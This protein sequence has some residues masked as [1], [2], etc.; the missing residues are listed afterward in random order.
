M[1]YTVIGICETAGALV[2]GPL[3]AMSFRAGLD[4]GGDWLGLP[5]I[6]AGSLFAV[7]AIALCSIGQSTLQ[8]IVVDL[9]DEDSE[10]P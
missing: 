7:A 8:R 1:L 9:E 3:L 2:A 6:A 4:W 5:Y 10:G